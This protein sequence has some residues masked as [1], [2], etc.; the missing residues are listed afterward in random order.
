[1]KLLRETLVR[2]NQLAVKRMENDIDYTLP[3]PIKEDLEL[4]VALR[5]R[6]VTSEEYE[7][8]MKKIREAFRDVH[9][10][11]SRIFWLSMSVFFVVTIPFVFYRLFKNHREMEK[12]VRE[13]NRILVHHGIHGKYPLGSKDG[14]GSFEFLAL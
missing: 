3:V 5:D 14:P 7:F 13:I 10:S 11:E 8:Y 12:R 4:P 6:G 9:G 2:C 1:M